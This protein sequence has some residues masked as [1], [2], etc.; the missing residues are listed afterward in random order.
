MPGARG[1]LDPQSESE[2]WLPEDEFWHYLGE[3]IVDYCNANRRILRKFAGISARS[4]E[5]ALSDLRT[6]NFISPHPDSP[7][8]RLLS[9]EIIG[10]CS[11]S[12]C[13]MGRD[14]VRLGRDCPWPCFFATDAGMI[15]RS[16]FALSASLASQLKKFIR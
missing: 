5:S 7:D 16:W 1:D 6:H 10:R 12:C 11:G 13:R 8:W 3:R 14:G 4:F 15:C 9:F 2:S